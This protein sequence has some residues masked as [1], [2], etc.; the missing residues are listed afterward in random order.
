MKWE[1]VALMVLLALLAAWVVIGPRVRHQVRPDASLTRFTLGPLKGEL[2]I[3]PGP[4]G[5]PAYRW[6]FRDG[7][8][9]QAVT[10]AELEAA[11]GREAVRR[12]TDQGGN[13]FFRGLNVTN[14]A[15]VA[16]VSVGLLGQA[17]FMGR[18]LTQWVSSEKK[19]QSIITLSFWWFSLAG[20]VLL[21]SYFAWRQDVVGV[22][23]QSVG[24]V[25]YSRNIRLIAKQRR[26]EARAAGA[27]PR[28]D[29]NSR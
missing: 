11:L 10:R 13:L 1:P 9:A 14:W 6:L 22:L 4:D 18:M 8:P 26:R 2:E 24:L 16:W 19:G 15:G 5:A 21:F 7:V 3:A 29:V 17:L 28:A 25:V 23:G 27:A 20:G 12:L